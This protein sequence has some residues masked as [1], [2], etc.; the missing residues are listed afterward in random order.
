MKNRD[1]I[2]DYFD[3]V[4]DGTVVSANDMYEHG[5]ERMKQ[6]AFFRAVERLA[7]EGE[8]IRVGRGM[9]IKK[10]DAQGD[11][12]ELL[13]N[14]FFGEDNSSG[15]FT[16]IH[17]YNKYALTNVKADNISLYS[18]VCK[19]SVCHISNMK[20]EDRQLS[21]ILIIQELLK[22]WKYSRIILIFHNLIKPSLQ[23][24][25][26]SLQGAMMMKLL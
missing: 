18:N 19:Q 6:E 15:M 10:S 17:L 12:T 20:P 26:S 7:D 21:W 5:F 22:Q 23:D 9:Y 2:L 13:L 8:I 16:G 4:A 14:Y 1:K 24:M 3:N 25:Q 11:I